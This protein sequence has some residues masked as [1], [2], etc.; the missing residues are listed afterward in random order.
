[1]NN[2]LRFLYRLFAA[3]NAHIL[4]GIVGLSQAGGIDETEQN[5]VNDQG[6]FNGA[7]INLGVDAV[8]GKTTCNAKDVVDSIGN[9]NF[10][11]LGSIGSLSEI[12]DVLKKI[13][14]RTIYLK[15]ETKIDFYVAKS[16]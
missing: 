13:D 15:L 5:A 3:L 12:G 14:L 4:Q 10:I 9:N 1:M 16:I 6:I 7:A 11:S 2:D 8:F